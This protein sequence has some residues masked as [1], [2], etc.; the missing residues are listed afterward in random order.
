MSKLEYKYGIKEI[1]ELSFDK[2]YDMYKVIGDI[3]K[4][5][6]IKEFGIELFKYL[7]KEDKLVQLKNEPK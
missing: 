6:E 3:N 1:A 4:L 2:S 5:D 7:G